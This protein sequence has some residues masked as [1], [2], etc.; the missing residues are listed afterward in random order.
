MNAIVPIA[1]RAQRAHHDRPRQTHFSIA[2]AS[3]NRAAGDAPSSAVIEALSDDIG[4][5]CFS[6]ST[7]GMTFG[8]AEQ[9]L[10]CWQSIIQGN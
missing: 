2:T 6:F 8:Q 5:P 4:T 10:S 7:C 1:A 3:P 9:L